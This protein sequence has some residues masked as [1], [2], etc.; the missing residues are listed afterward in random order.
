EV[1]V[2]ESDVEQRLQLLSDTRLVLEEG[3]SIF[4][5]LLQHVGDAESTE[6]NFQSLAVVTLALADIA[7]DVDVG[8][9]MH[10]DLDETISLARLATPAFHVEGE[11]TRPVTA[12]LRLRQLGEQLTNRREETRVRR[13]VGARG[14]PDRTLIDVDDLVQVLETR[15]ARMC[16]GDNSRPIEMSRHRAVQDV[17]DQRRLAAARDASHCD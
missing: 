16:T 3:E 9:K 13:R 6:A 7:R 15:D 1:D 14:A 10:L 12:D 4:D 5:R 17:L 2:A 8:K 11:A